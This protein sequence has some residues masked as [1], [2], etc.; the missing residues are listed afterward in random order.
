MW[1]AQAINKGAL[2]RGAKPRKGFIVFLVLFCCCRQSLDFSVYR[3]ISP[4][5]SQVSAKN[6]TLR[7]SVPRLVGRF[8]SLRS[9]GLALTAGAGHP[10]PDL[11]LSAGRGKLLE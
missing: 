8:H 1:N 6:V 11:L 2:A 5:S 4:F 3:I 9:G 7:I 10:A